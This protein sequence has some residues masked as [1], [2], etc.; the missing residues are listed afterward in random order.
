MYSQEEA[1]NIRL[2]FWDRFERYSFV[3][4]RQKGKPGKWVMNK[5]GIRQLKLKFHFDQKTASVGIDIETRNMD[6]RIALFNKL[7]ELKPVLEKTLG[8]EM[9]WELDFILPTGKS[10][11]RIYLCLENVSIYDKE[12]WSEVFAFFY[13][14]MIKIERFFQEYQE[15]LKEAQ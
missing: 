3:R 12:T 1:K 2:E 4:R 10:I 6:K 9:I 7:E 15:I 13:K 14:K 8:E 11:S 5:T